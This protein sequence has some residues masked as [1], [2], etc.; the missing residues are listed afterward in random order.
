MDPT[1]HSG[2]TDSGVPDPVTLDPNAFRVPHRLA[3]I[4]VER[5]WGG[6]RLLRDLHPDLASPES[7][8]PIG[9]TWGVSDVGDD[10][11][12]HSRVIGG[13]ADGWTLRELLT[14]APGEMLGTPGAPPRLPLLYKFID[15]RQNLSVQVHPPD[16]LVAAR[17]IDGAGKTEAWLIID[18]DPG[19][20]IIYGFEDG[21]T[22]ADYLTH[23]RAGDGRFGLREYEVHAGDLIYLPSGTVHAIGAGI[24]LAEIQQS[25]DTTYRIYDWDRLGLDGQPRT[26]HL[27]E[28]SWIE[29]PSPLP[30]C[31]YH[32]PDADVLTVDGAFHRRLRAEPFELWEWSRAE[33]RTVTLPESASF[34]IFSVLAG[35]ARW[36]TDT[37]HVETRAGDSGLV[38][39]AAGPVRVTPTRG[40]HLLWMAP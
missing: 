4:P 17:G 22:Y 19:A 27:D 2:A 32:P 21:V 13:P 38:P 16:E 11:K 14:A 5:V 12:L 33:P 9:E 28:A 3:P 26:L 31:P 36:E 35:S 39:A 25:S 34:G 6:E 15:A 37:G 10:P 30:P 18:A 20:T 40:A 8:A 29:P 7:G 1:I 23:A 24:L